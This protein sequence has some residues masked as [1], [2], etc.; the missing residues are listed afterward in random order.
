MN[1][2]SLPAVVSIYQRV[3]A[4]LGITHYANIS[5]KARTALQASASN[6]DEI[7]IE[8]I[9]M[10]DL[11]RFASNVERE[12]HETISILRDEESRADGLP[13][14]EPLGFDK[15]LQTTR[16]ELV[17]NLAKLSKLDEEIVHIQKLSID[18]REQGDEELVVELH[19]RLREKQ[20]ERQARLEV[21]STN[22]RILTSQIN[23]IKET[24]NS[25][26]EKDVGLGEKK[27]FI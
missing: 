15:A 6:L 9:P 2:T 5:R 10:R 18:A 3:C 22:Q 20:D 13:L 7:E 24:I 19:K 25:V 27:N 16:G 14:R 23:T 17:N 4:D 26:L 1:I 8:N 21:A 11:P 12:T